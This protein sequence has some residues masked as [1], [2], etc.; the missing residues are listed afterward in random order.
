MVS[1]SIGASAPV[2]PRSGQPFETEEGPAQSEALFDLDL[3]S[4][5]IAIQR[6]KWP[7]VGIVT[8]AL[9]LGFVVT[10]LT[11]PKYVATSRVLIEQEV[12]QI[13]EDKGPARIAP[14]DAQ[15]F[16]STQVDVLKS[17]SLAQRVVESEGLADDAAFYDSLGVKMADEGDLTSATN[18]PGDLAAFRRDLAVELLTKNLT[19]NLPLNSRLV[20]IMFTSASPDMSA[21]IANSVATNY[22]ES[23]LARKFDSSAYAREFLSQQL[24]DARKK[25]EQSERDL[26]QYSREAGLIRVG[27]QG[28]NADKETTLSVTNESLVQINSAAATATSQR[29]AA[30]DRWENLRNQPILSI[31][32]VLNNPAV[33]SL[34]TQRSTI[35]SDLAEESVKH[36]DDHP[37][38]QALESQLARIDSQI[39][40]LGNSIKRSARLEYE[41]AK[42]R[43][44]SLQS[45]V[46]GLRSEALDEQDRGVQYNVLR[47]EA[48]TAR[49]L[50]E[51]LLTRYNELSA[52]AGAASNNV[53][54]VDVAER[55]NEPDSPNPVLNMMLA[56]LAG[57]AAAAAFVFLR[58][59]FDDVMRSPEDVERKLGVPMLALIPKVEDEVLTEDLA[60]PKSP[61][62]EAYLSLLT[63]LRYSSGDGLPKTMTV[64]SATASEGK[65]TTAHTLA[66]E[67]ASQNRRTLLIDADLRRPTLH[68][69]L[70]N[71][72]QLGFTSLL[73]GEKNL[74]DV[75]VPGPVANLYYMTALPIPPS[76]SSLLATAD[77]EGIIAEL[78]KDYDH[79]I[80]DSP[81]VLGLSDALTIAV[82]VD[83]LLFVVDASAGKR[84]SVKTSMRRLQMVGAPIAGVVLTK[85]DASKISGAY[86]YYGY[87]YYAYGEEH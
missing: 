59:Q 61:I 55:P 27:G 71:A 67:I 58:E 30:Q 17:Q 60:D 77:L 62:S 48:E 41:A 72:D 39:D 79:I 13:L 43:E 80:F 49:A 34:I 8:A 3:R 6:N 87:D 7:I 68:R 10:L 29:V 12:E 38:V 18:Y 1:D 84:G 74:L 2:T 42:D 26:N 70:A 85:F 52:T 23:N 53:S 21:R 47:R 44:D 66:K 37:N 56:F 19:V 81:P 75:I 63:N 25:L 82:H 83:R 22:I 73:A 5:Y 45:R 51:A 14:L 64:V 36:L 69:R 20:S 15:L 35:Q 40:S 54:L 57:I 46:S 31:P 11:V 28:Q 86:S 65:T 32:E 9:V 78:S 24:A 33:Q 16:L 76:P 4:I 50:Y